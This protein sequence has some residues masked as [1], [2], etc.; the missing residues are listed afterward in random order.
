VHAEVFHWNTA[1]MRVLEKAGYVREGVLR[2]SV[3]KDRQWADQV[4]FARIVPGA[5]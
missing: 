2:K 4:V 1:S 5:E 3:Y